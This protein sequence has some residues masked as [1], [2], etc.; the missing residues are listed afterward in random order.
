MPSAGHRGNSARLEGPSSVF[1]LDGWAPP[2]LRQLA[3]CPHDRQTRARETERPLVEQVARLPAREELRVEAVEALDLEERIAKR[4][5]AA[6]QP[7]QATSRALHQAREGR[8]VERDLLHSAL[9]QRLDCVHDEEL[10]QSVRG[11]PVPAPR[12]ERHGWASVRGNEVKEAA[13]ATVGVAREHDEAAGPALG[14]ERVHAHRETA[15]GRARQPANGY[16]LELAER[17]FVEA[18]KLCERRRV[19]ALLEPCHRLAHLAYR[20]TIQR[21]APSFDDRFVAQV[22][23]T[24]ARLPP[25]RNQRFADAA[26]RQ[27]RASPLGVRRRL[28]DEAGQGGGWPNRVARAEQDAV[29]DPV[30]EEGGAGLVEQVLLVAAELEERE[31]VGAVAADEP[32]GEAPGLGIGKAPRR[33]ERPEHEI[34]DR[35]QRGEREQGDGERQVSGLVVEGDRAGLPEHG[36]AG[37]SNDLSEGGVRRRER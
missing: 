11:L 18:G 25:E 6:G 3:F 9:A 23:R 15:L 10:G 28:R 17:A 2:R 13:D 29:F 32:P 26:R 16:L 1:T 30:G 5:Q 14:P 37:R 12:R 24:Q 22:E 33:S 21:E 20:P 27:L 34:G 4:D 36:V 35:Q 7:L 19:A 8:E 31:R